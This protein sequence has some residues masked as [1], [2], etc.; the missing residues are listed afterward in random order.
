M[1]WHRRQKADSPHGKEPGRKAVDL[2]HQERHPDENTISCRGL[3]GV[4][5]REG[6]TDEAVPWTPHERGAGKPSARRELQ[7]SC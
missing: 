2:M 7:C 5:G 3:G 4:T 6:G 1:A